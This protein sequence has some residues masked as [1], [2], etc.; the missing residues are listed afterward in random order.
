[1]TYQAGSWTKPRRVVAKVEWH[2]GELY[3]RVGFIVTNLAR[4]AANVVAFYNK[5]GT[6][7]QWIKE[8]K[9]AIR[10]TRLSCRSFAA[11]AVRLQLHALAYNLGN[12]LRTPG[13]A[14]ADQRLVADE[15]QGKADQ[16]RREDR[17]PWSLCRFPDGRSRHSENSLCRRPAADRGV[18]AATRY[19]DS[20]M[21]SVW[22]STKNHGRRAS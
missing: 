11:N 3:T 21:R 18:A 8:G 10:W 2:P 22:R 15:P 5:R 13:D 19:I 4:P 9:G 1:M 14:R 20:V 16:D 7:E 17:Q 6:C 12:F